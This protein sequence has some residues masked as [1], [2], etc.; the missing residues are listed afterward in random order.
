M[1]NLTTASVL[2]FER[3]LDISDGALTQKKSGGGASPKIVGIREKAVRGTISNRLK[4]AIT[5]DSA[6]MDAE[7]QKPNL[8]I[9]DV[10]T[11]D[12]GYDTLVCDWTCKLLPFDGAPSICTD[13]AYRARVMEVVQGYVS[14]QGLG[15]LARRYATNIVNA[16]WLWRNRMGAF[17]V[18]VTVRFTVDQEE[19][20]LPFE[21]AESLSL[22][23]PLSESP[24]LTVLAAEIER[25][26]TNGERPQLLKVHAEAL[27]GE[28]QEVY[29][30]Q[31]LVLDSGD[32]KKKV[33][34]QIDGATGQAG[35][36]S[37]KIGNA[38]RTIDT[39]YSESPRFPISVE[40]YGSVTTLGK[41]F[42]QPSA[43]TDFYTLFD[44]WVV[45]EI[46]PDI[47]QQHFVMAVLLRGGVFGESS[48]DKS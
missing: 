22:N 6:K 20:T 24:E 35:I 4:A 33:L 48:K 19:I 47:E 43:K 27:I 17:R 7:T 12:S 32:R 37:Q 23:Q 28:Q 30:S 11:L 16:R 45:R 31:E 14:Q 34:Y 41:A 25:V 42:R 38:I 13:E 40:P 44:D 1:T 36:H 5:R 15:E 18:D 2:A 9:V 10:A 3:K 46:E 21:Q 8:Q 29:P 39:W 26:L